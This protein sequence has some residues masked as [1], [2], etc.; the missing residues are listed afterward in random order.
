MVGNLLP[1]HTHQRV[2]QRESNGNS[3][4]LA[5]A[6][7]LNCRDPSRSLSAAVVAGKGWS[8]VMRKN[9]ASLMF[10]GCVALAGPVLAA[11]GVNTEES[12]VK[13]QS[14]VA[15]QQVQMPLPGLRDEAA[16]VLVGTALIGLGAALRRSA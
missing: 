1:W 9:V 10:A 6:Y 8:T 11:P 2:I 3:S 15:V 16:M 13:S 5:V 12:S 14:A 4:T 7:R